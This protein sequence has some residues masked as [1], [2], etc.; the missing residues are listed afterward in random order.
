MGNPTLKESV[1]GRSAAFNESVELIISSKT[2]SQRQRNSMKPSSMVPCAP[3]FV[4]QQVAPTSPSTMNPQPVH[5]PTNRFHHMFHARVRHSSVHMNIVPHSTGPV[6]SY[7]VNLEDGHVSV[8]GKSPSSWL[9]RPTAQSVKRSIKYRCPLCSEL[10]DTKGKVYYH[11]K[12]YHRCSLIS[13]DS[14]YYC[15]KCNDWHKSAYTLWNHLRTLRRGPVQ[16]YGPDSQCVCACAC[17][18]VCVVL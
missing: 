13:R 11:I 15:K 7:M 12:K 4:Y 3:G 17:A 8:A 5:T 1:P 6:C 16:R 10:L 2:I 18:C 14:P 9:H